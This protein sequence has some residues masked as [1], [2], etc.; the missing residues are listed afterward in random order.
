MHNRPAE[1]LN[2]QL[3][4]YLKLKEENEKIKEQVEALKKNQ[5]VK[6][7]EIAI[8]RRNLV[9]VQQEIIE[10]LKSRVGKLNWNGSNELK[11]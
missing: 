10:R 2:F 8:I 4:E 11:V 6:E 3:E 9:Q 5:F 1:S 7:G